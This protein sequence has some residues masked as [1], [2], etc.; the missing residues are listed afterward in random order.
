MTIFAAQTII[1]NKDF[2]LIKQL[3]QGSKRAFETIYD[4]YVTM[5]YR[6]AVTLLRD[7]QMAED[8]VQFVFMQLWEHRKEI[9]TDKNL[10]AYLY[11]IA[12]NAV[13]KELR[14]KVLFARFQQ[15]EMI[16]ADA[17]QKP[18]DTRGDYMIIADQLR[19]AVDAMPESRKNIWKLKYEQKLSIAEIA[20]SLGI[21]PKTVETQL[22]RAKISLSESISKI[23]S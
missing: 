11:V 12:K 19:N 8:I 22:Y 20:H 13:Y 5:V 9:S 10:P 21:S 2:L 18:S 3:N 6:Y 23:V 7:C 15:N 14:R 4:R 17:F 1:M 16:C